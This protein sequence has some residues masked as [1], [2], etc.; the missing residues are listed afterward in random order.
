MA[1]RCFSTCDTLTGCHVASTV[2]GWILCCLHSF[3]WPSNF[4]R[5]Y[6]G[7][8]GV[9]LRYDFGRQRREDTRSTPLIAQ[10][11]M[12]VWRKAAGK[13]HSEH[14]FPAL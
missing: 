3:N 12:S 9:I 2:F 13:R 10:S 4:R 5:C 6:R 8:R 1:D 14:H 7:A 11:I